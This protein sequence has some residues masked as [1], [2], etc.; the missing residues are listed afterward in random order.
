LSYTVAELGSVLGNYEDS[1][2]TYAGGWDLLQDIFQ[3]D[4]SKPI[5][6]GGFGALTAVAIDENDA[7]DGQDTEMVFRVTDPDDNDRF[8]QKNGYYSSYES[9]VWDGRFFE[10]E[11]YEELVTK[12]RKV[13]A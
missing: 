4:E 12:Y 1:R 8:F 11:P 13:S 10:V 5:L 9:F 2:Y 3:D 6:L 7:G